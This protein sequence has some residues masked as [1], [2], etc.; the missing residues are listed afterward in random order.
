MHARVTPD[1][2]RRLRQNA[3]KMLVI[4]KWT[5]AIGCV[6]LVGSGMLR[7]PLPRFLL[8]NL[9]ATLPKSAV[10]FGFGY[11]ASAYLPLLQRHAVA[12]MFALCLLGA[13]AV[14]LIMRRPDHA[15]R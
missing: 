4:G 15:A 5:H 3:A 9:L 14:A 6:V 2:R 1:L 12:T 10:L 13:V 7:L 8:V 11:F